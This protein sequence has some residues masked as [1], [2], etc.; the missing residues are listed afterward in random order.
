[1]VIM[2]V[3]NLPTTLECLLKGLLDESELLSWSIHGGKMYTQPCIRFAV[4]NMDNSTLEQIVY[5]KCINQGSCRTER[6]QQLTGIL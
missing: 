1:M 4:D 5:K 3:D 6:N 2:A